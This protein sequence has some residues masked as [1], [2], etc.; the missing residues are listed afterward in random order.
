MSCWLLPD[1]LN[2]VIK[3]T[4]EH[5]RS[6]TSLSAEIFGLML[7][8]RPVLPN[9]TI[10]QSIVDDSSALVSLLEEVS[11]TGIATLT[12]NVPHPSN[13]HLTSLTDRSLF[14]SSDDPLK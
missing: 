4:E 2:G 11:D 7:L 10:E 9:F 8:T 3:K 12:I 6:R 5:P 13:V 1:T 14:T